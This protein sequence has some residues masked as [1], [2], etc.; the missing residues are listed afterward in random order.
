MFV[1]I[2]KSLTMSLLNKRPHS[3]AVEVYSKIIFSFEATLLGN[4]IAMD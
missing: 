4:L 2:I 3:S 1:K